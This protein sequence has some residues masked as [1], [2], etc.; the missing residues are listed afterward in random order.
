MKLGNEIKARYRI[1][2]EYTTVYIP[3]QNRVSER[4]NRT[5]VQLARGMLL[6]TGLPNWMWGYTI[7]AAYYI[8][9]RTPVRPK[10]LTPEEAYSGRRPYIGHLR[11]FGCLV[12]VHVPQ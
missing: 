1:P 12:Y 10:G 8:R 3:E 7:E 11:A 2:F 5:L 6:G 9:N 4:L